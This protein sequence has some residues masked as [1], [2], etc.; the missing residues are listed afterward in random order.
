[1]YEELRGSRKEVT[2]PSASLPCPGTS[3]PANGGG[4]DFLP[5]NRVSK[6]ARGVYPAR[7][8]RPPLADGE[9]G[10]TG[11][12]NQWPAS[13][14]ACDRNLGEYLTVLAEKAVG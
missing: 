14:R 8:H 5:V 10:A 3:F 12:L 7:P 4:V 11:R 6:Q 13:F 1:M 9:E 2:G